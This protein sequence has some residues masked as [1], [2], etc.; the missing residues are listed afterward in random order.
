MILNRPYPPILRSTAASRTLPA[1]GASTCAS[2]SHVWNG[3]EGI[4]TMNP[5]RRPK[6]IPSFIIGENPGYTS[7]MRY[8]MSKLGVPV[9]SHP[10]KY[11][12]NIARSIT[13]LATWV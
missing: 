4:F 7:V 2:G 12:P 6:N 3:T 13:R 5:N 9:F 1:V 8:I 11:R 10:P